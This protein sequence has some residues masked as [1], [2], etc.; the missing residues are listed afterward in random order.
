MRKD[1]I[2]SWSDIKNE[3]DNFI[4]RKRTDY[5]TFH[6]GTTIP[7][8]YHKLF[9]ENLSKEVTKG[10]FVS[11]KLEINNKIYNASVRWPNSK[12]RNGV[13]I[14]LLY[15]QKALLEL[16][17]EKLEVSY[18]YII[19]YMYE[20]NEKK[21]ATIPDEFEE[22]LDFYKGDKKDTFVVKI[23]SKKNLNIIEEDYEDIESDIIEDT[24]DDN[25]IEMNFSVLDSI[26]NIYNYIQSK[27]FNYKEEVIKN[28]Y[29]ALKTK[30]F[31]ILSGISGTGKSKIIELFAEAI[32]ATSKNGRFNLVPVKPDW[33]DSTD[34]LG[35]RNIEG[36]FNP[37]FIT[38]IAYEAMKNPNM[39]YFLC[40]DEMNLARVEY[41]FSDVLSLMETRKFNDD[42]DIITNMLLGKE[43]IGSDNISYN[44]YGDVYLP[45]NLYIVGTVNM[46]ET[47]FPFSKKVLDRTNAI[48]FNEVNLNFSFD[49]VKSKDISSKTYDNS[50][51][52]SEFIKLYDCRDYKEIATNVIDRLIK[53]NGILTTYNQH[54][55]YRVRDEIVF[56]MIYATRENIMDF[57]VAWDF[58]IT[59]KILPKISGSGSEV[60]EILVKLFKHF[61][62][63]KSSYSDYITEEELKDMESKV[64]GNEYN[65]INKKLLHMIRRYLRDGFTT[66]WQ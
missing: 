15:S 4:G 19:N 1:K 3:N 59:Q 20:N 65:I 55:G 13:T 40:L 9:L 64:I 44:K 45:Q 5:S 12:G 17:K 30:P 62:N 24:D 32:G 28:L 37:G 47:T 25:I 54:F 10:N 21:P 7:M 50:L 46:D 51:L 63:I 2:D 61:N 58:C 60:L 31:V 53:I 33:S 34:L 35:Y 22:Y 18:N 23:M 41:Y 14:Q 38:S 29:I 26:D 43:Q 27:G 48:E 11:V 57:D 49:E 56:Y 16:L 6:K 52:K 66:Y 8:R 42:G 36:K 39:P